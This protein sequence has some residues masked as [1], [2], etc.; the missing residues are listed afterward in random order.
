VGE[1]KKKSQQPGVSFIRSG[2]E[3]EMVRRIVACFKGKTFPAPATAYIW[4][5]IISASLSLESP[6]TVSA[7]TAETNHDIYW[8]TREYFGNFISIAKEP[9]SKRVLGDVLDGKAGV[10]VLPLPGGTTEWSWWREL[11][12]GIKVFACLPFI[13]AKGSEIQAL[14]VAKIEPE[15]SGDDVTLLSIETDMDISQSRLKT[16]F[17]KQKLATRWL[18]AET[19]PSKH[20]LHLVEIKSFIKAENEAIKMVKK[21][22]GASLIAIRELGAYALPVTI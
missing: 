13:L 6:L 19:L 4:R 8:L 17:D 10:G 21:D 15:T 3:A 11:P 5:M 7:Y 2:R 12:E 20:R 18:A 1:L 14:A 16:T 9:T 22:I